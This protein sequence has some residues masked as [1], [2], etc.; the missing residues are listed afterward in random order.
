MTWFRPFALL[1]AASLSLGVA[2]QQT[3]EADYD[4]R[5]QKLK[6]LIE[7]L[8]RE[9][10]AVK[11]SR[12]D[13]QLDLQK[14]E[15]EIGDLINKIDTLKHQLKD[16][17]G[18]LKKLN[19]EQKQL[20]DAKRKQQKHIAQQVSAIYRMGRQSNAKLL[21]NQ[22]SPERISRLV[23]YYDYFL[24]ARADKVA[25]YIDTLAGLDEIEP[26]IVRK[27]EA[28][29]QNRQQLQRRHHQLSDRQQERERALAQLNQAITDKDAELRR[30]D[31]AR[32]RLP[33]LLQ[34]VAEA[35]ATIPLPG[36][37]KP[38]SS[39]KGRLPWPTQGKLQHRFGSARAGGK[40]KWDG[41]LI[42]A[43]AGREVKAVH[44]GQVVFADYLRGHGLLLILDHG[45]GYMSLYAHNQSLLSDT[46]D[47]VAAGESIAAVGNSGGR[48]RAGLYFEI[49]H[50][51][52]PTNPSRWL[53]SN[54]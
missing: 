23:R 41:V 26:R 37:G 25:T 40:L 24:D 51:G 7:Q 16:Q 22:E 46:G 44:H 11:G 12:T 2:A 29:D 33:Q 18:Q 52:K 53:A 54:R 32:E 43:A 45:A 9:L 42:R 27:T 30:A 1:L 6:G 34:Q 48:D 50:R 20:K 10:K 4:E 21:L 47:W 13:L 15:T 36:N 38:F 49:R 19:T 3:S 14:S 35:V 31:A 39:L 28:L 17:K 5:L 8:N